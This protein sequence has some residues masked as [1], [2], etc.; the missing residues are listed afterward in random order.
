MDNDLPRIGESVYAVAVRQGFVVP[1]WELFQGLVAYN[2]TG[3]GV[4]TR[5]YP[6]N[7][8]WFTAV[9][10]YHG[11]QICVVP[12]EN[13]FYDAEQAQQVLID[14]LAE[15]KIYKEKYEAREKERLDAE[16]VLRKGGLE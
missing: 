8:E 14:N 11:N 1:Y 16:K 12:I 13:I 10:D 3:S 9:K 5:F 4:P 6:E 15:A 7:S 2:M